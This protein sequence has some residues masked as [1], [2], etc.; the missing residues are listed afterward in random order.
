M[1]KRSWT[2]ILLWSLLAIIGTPIVVIFLIIVLLYIPP[3]Q[4]AVV[5]RTCKEI[6]QKSGYDV[7]IGSINLILP[8]KLKVRDYSMS[9]ND[10]VYLQGKRSGL[11]REILPTYLIPGESTGPVPVR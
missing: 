3:V 7:E 10:S 2:R 11:L 5:D 9:K 6:S 1:R 4:R 8:L